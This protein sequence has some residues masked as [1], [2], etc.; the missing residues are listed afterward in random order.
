MILYFP[1]VPILHLI[2]VPF[3]DVWHKSSDNGDNVDHGSV[4]DIS[5]ILRAFVAEYLQL[6][7]ASSPQ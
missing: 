3:P 1:G 6:E 4:S 7:V 2:V 5:K